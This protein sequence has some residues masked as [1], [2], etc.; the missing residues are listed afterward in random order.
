MSQIEERNVEGEVGSS[1][2][3]ME[4]DIE[5]SHAGRKTASACSDHKISTLGI[6]AVGKL[7]VSGAKCR[8]SERNEKK[9]PDED[10]VGS[11]GSKGEEVDVDGPEDEVV[12]EWRIVS[13][14]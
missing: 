9:D 7:E 2:A 8:E 11:E 10:N 6:G 5:P 12:A 1:Q 4:Q 13:R 14:C 3:Q